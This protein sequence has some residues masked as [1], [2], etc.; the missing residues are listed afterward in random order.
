MIPIDFQIFQRGR[1]TTNQYFLKSLS[2]FCPHRFGKVVPFFSN[3]FRMAT[4]A[5]SAAQGA[6]GT[7]AAWIWVK[8]LVLLVESQTRGPS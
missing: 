6:M 8:S 5:R 1:Y 7:D 2:S 3:V 4:C